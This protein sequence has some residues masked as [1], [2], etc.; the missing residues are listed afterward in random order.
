[1]PSSRAPSDE[2]SPV[3]NQDPRAD[4]LT[5]QQPHQ[6][7][8]EGTRHDRLLP[9][10]TTHR[11]EGPDH[12]NLHEQ[13]PPPP[14][15]AGTRALHSRKISLTQ[16]LLTVTS[17]RTQRRHQGESQQSNGT[18][19]THS[20]AHVSSASILRVETKRRVQKAE[21]FSTSLARPEPVS[22]RGEL[23]PNPDSPSQRERERREEHECLQ[24]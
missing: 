7:R 14:T 5:N 16:R 15:S 11:Y 21:T 3:H 6:Y 19:R 13:Q 12:A 8:N 23:K 22:M 17:F 20:A 2:T 1:M 10:D 4:Q 18:P 9:D 24:R